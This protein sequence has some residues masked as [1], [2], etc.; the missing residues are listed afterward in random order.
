MRELELMKL[1]NPTDMV[2]TGESSDGETAILMVTG[3]L[4][5][6]TAQG[7]ITKT[8]EMGRR[9]DQYQRRLGVTDRGLST[10]P[11]FLQ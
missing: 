10:V 6:E 5:G 8:K 1:M 9:L 4:E 3:V 2:V 11:G 7:E